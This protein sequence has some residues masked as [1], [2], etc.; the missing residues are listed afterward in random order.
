LAD[1]HVFGQNLRQAA[2]DENTRHARVS[3]RDALEDQ[4]G[5][6]P[7]DQHAQEHDPAAPPGELQQVGFPPAFGLVSRRAARFGHGQRIWLDL[8]KRR[9]GYLEKS[10][11]GL[12]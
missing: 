2:I 10:V 5:G 7:S 4:P 1:L 6:A 3:R 8:D 11:M 12:D 9:H